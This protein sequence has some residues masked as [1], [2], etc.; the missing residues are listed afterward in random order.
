MIGSDRT[1]PV[2]V[3]ESPMPRASQRY[4][5]RW[6]I[7]QPA[8]AALI[9]ALVTDRPA[10]D[11]LLQ[12][13]ALRAISAYADRVPDADFT[14][15]ALDHA[16]AEVHER[17]FL[18]ALADADL[19]RILADEV[20]VVAT[21]SEDLRGAL[22]TC[23]DAV[24]G[25]AWESLKRHYHAGQDDVRIA[26]EVA[27]RPASVR[28]QLNTTRAELR[29]GVIRAHRDPG[30]RED[31]LLRAHWDGTLQAEDSAR[32]AEWLR[33]DAG[34]RGALLIGGAVEGRLAEMVGSRMGADSA[35]VE[36]PQLDGV[37]GEA[38]TAAFLRGDLAAAEI[39]RL[40]RWLAHDAIEARDLL[41]R[42]IAVTDDAQEQ[43]VPS[44]RYEP[45]TDQT[46][47]RLRRAL[48]LS[49]R[50]ERRRPNPA[51][52]AYLLALL[53]LAIAAL[54]LLLAPPGS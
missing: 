32:F 36:R 46:P 8:V 5:A 43:K 49:D 37:Y 4:H 26:R 6:I 22:R 16:R 13:V 23:L 38:M 30:Y 29:A 25:R 53:L 41:L 51:R 3:G 50:R 18:T 44:E 33:A 10:A 40:Q 54:L 27:L 42:E 47:V 39:P 24:T 9:Y 17:H 34:H 48:P 11:L 52:A 15:W 7:A 31:P 1:T 21:D 20:V 35:L 12:Q 14:R 28:T 19:L 45:S 2:A